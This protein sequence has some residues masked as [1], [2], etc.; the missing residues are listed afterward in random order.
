[1]AKVFLGFNRRTADGKQ[2]TFQAPKFGR[3][4]VCCNQDAR[5][6]TMQFQPSTERISADAVEV[7]VCVECRDHALLQP[8]TGIGAVTLAVLGACFTALGVGKLVDRPDDG[9]LRVFALAGAGMLVAGVV[10]LVR[11]LRRERTARAA[12]HHPGLRFIVGLVGTEVFTSND[13]LADTLV[14]LNPGAIKAMEERI[15]TARV[16]AKR[17]GSAGTSSPPPSSSTGST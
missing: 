4:C 12:G 11:H 14:E 8:T 16:V 10:L 7:P 6:M 3:D 9:F 13:A 15:P 17:Q 5:W 2:L 1:M